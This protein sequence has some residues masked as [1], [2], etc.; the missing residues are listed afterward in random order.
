MPF[1]ATSETWS[2]DTAE[3]GQFNV[4]VESSKV[5]FEGTSATYSRVIVGGSELLFDEYF[6]T[7]TNYNNGDTAIAL[8][9]TVSGNTDQSVT[10][11]PKSFTATTY[12]IDASQ[13]FGIGITFA[14]II[15]IVIIV[16]GIVI[17]V[18]RRHL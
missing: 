14:V 3:R 8:F 6:I 4:L 2:E 17:W 7:A 5:R 13:Q 12:E 18:R 1:D 9:N 10:I 11:T 15:P 16:I